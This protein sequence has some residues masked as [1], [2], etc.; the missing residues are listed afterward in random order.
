MC[1]LATLA[2]AS[3]GVPDA[4]HAQQD[5]RSPKRIELI[6]FYGEGCPYC[7]RELAFL[8]DLQ[9]RQPLLDVAAHEVW[10]NAEN[11]E[12]FQSMAAAHGIDARAVP[13]TFIGDSFWVGFDST[14]Q[15]QIEAAVDALAEGAAPPP[16]EE[17]TTIDVPFVGKVDV[18]DSSLVVATLLIGFVDG[19]N[20]CSL[21]VLSMLLAL[22][23]HSGSRKR[24]IVV[25][26]VFL[27]VTSA[28]YGLYMIGA[29]SALDYAGEVTWVRLAVAVVA[30]TFGV[31]HL[32]EYVTHRG[33]SLTIADEKKPGM[34]GRMRGI[35]RPERSLPAV[36]GGTVVLAV[37]VSLAE[38]PCTAGLPLLWTDLLSS[39]DVPVSGAVVLFI[40][41]LLVF[42]LDELIVFGAAVITLRSTKLQ[43]RH[44]RIL[45]LVS[46]TLMV[47]LAVTM[48][49][50]PQLLESVSGTAAV[51]AAAALVIVGVIALDHRVPAHHP[52]PS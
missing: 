11:R 37:G 51:F 38:T 41:Y 6:V 48:L 45:Q 12:L 18:G 40:L 9:Q 1:M 25:G 22:V 16:V 28:L 43:E 39:R 50:A 33:P 32:K 17:R 31:L 46:G 26:M 21:W 29:Y 52:R 20:P 34:F 15:R 42:L 36:L 4:A 8:S 13:T 27:T 19:I 47:A 5:D 14:V 44:G 10:N 30:G 3:V 24:I 35:A 7:A 23:L 2:L 49:L